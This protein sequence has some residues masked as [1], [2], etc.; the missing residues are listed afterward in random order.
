MEVDGSDDFPF[1]MGRFKM[2]I[3]QGVTFMPHCEL[4]CF[5]QDQKG[6]LAC[7][8]LANF[9]LEVVLGLTWMCFFVFFF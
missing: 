1:Q 8:V 7:F 5:G 4:V 2:L 3:F 9:P 6:F